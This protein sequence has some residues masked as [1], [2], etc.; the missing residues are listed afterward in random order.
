MEALAA[1]LTRERLLVELVVFKLVE[2]R[3]LLLAGEAR[4]LGWAAEEVERADRCR[5]R[6]AELERA[7]LVTGLATDRGLPAG[8]A[9]A[10]RPG[11]GRARAVAHACSPRRRRAL[12]AERRRGGRAADRHAP[13]RRG[14]QPRAGRDACASSTAHRTRRSRCAP[15]TA[16]PPA[17]RPPVPAPASRTSCSPCQLLRP[18]ASAS[19]RWP[20]P[21]AP[22]RSRR[23]TSPTPT[24][25]ASPGS[26]SPCR[27]RC[28]P[29]ARPGCAATDSAAWASRSCR[30]TACA[31]GW[32]TSPGAARPASRRPRRARAEGLT[33]TESVVGNYGAGAPERAVGVPVGLGRPEPAPERRRGPQHRPVDRR[34]PRRQPARPAPRASTASAPSCGPRIG[35]QLGELNGLLTHVDGAQQG[36]PARRG[37]R[38][39]PQ[40]PATTSATPRSTAS[41]RCPAP[42]VRPGADG[43][44]EVYLGGG[45]ARWP[46][47]TSRSCRPRAPVPRP[48]CARPTAADVPAG[49]QL[50]GY[51]SVLKADLPPFGSQ[52]DALAAGL[53]DAGERD[54]RPQPGPRRRAGRRV[55]HRHRRPRPARCRPRSP[56]ARSPRAC[57]A[58]RDDGEGALAMSTLRTL[59]AVDGQPLGAAVR[60]FG[61]RVGQAVTDAGRSSGTAQ[62]GPAGRDADPQRRERR[63]HRRGDGRPREVPARLLGGLARHHHRRRDAGQDHQRDG[64]LMRV[65]T[66]N[67][68]LTS[69][70]GLGA[71]LGRVQEQS[72]KLSSGKSISK[73][74][75][76]AP[77]AATAEALRAGEAD[78]ESFA[79]SAADAKGWLD[80]ADG[81]L[82][83]MSSV[84]IRVRELAASAVNGSL[85]ATSR[86]AI[87]DE[88]A[89][90]RDQLRDL[91]QTRY[92]DRPLFGGFGGETGSAL[93]TDAR[94][95]GHL[96]GRQRAGAPPGQPDRAPAGQRRRPGAV[97]LRHR[98]GRGRLRDPRRPVDRGPR[99]RRRPPSPRCRAALA[100]HADAVGRGLA[101]VGA[102]TNRV[103]SVVD[104]GSTVARRPRQ[105]PQRASRTSTSPRPSSSST[106]RR[107]AT[108]PRSAPP[109][110]PTCRAWRTSSGS[111]PPLT[112]A[113][114][115]Q[116]GHARTPPGRTPGARTTTDGRTPRTSPMAPV[117]RPLCSRRAPP[118]RRPAPPCSTPS[119]RSS[120]RWPADVDAGLVVAAPLL[121]GRDRAPAGQPRPGRA[122]SS[123]TATPPPASARSPSPA[124]GPP[125]A[126]PSSSTRPPCPTGPACVR[127]RAG[128][129][130]P[131][132]SCCPP[133]C[134]GV[135]VLT[136]AVDLAAL[137]ALVLSTQPLPVDDGD[138]G[139][140][141][142]ARA[143]PGVPG[144]PGLVS[145]VVPVW[146]QLE[147]TRACLASL[148]RT[149]RAPYEVVVVD[150]GSTDGTRAWLAAQRDVVVVTNAENRGFAAACNQGVAA[151]RGEVVV[152]LNNDTQV[153]RGWVEGL[154]DA[155]RR[156]P[157]DRRR[158]PPL[159]PRLRP[160]GRCTSPATTP[161]RSTAPPPSGGAA[162]T[163]AAAPTVHPAGRLL[164]RRPPRRAAARPAAWTRATAP[165]A[166]RTTTSACA[167]AG[168]AGPSGSP[169]RCSSTT[170]AARP[171]APPAP[172]PRPS[173]T[174]TGTTAPSGAPPSART[175]CVGRPHRQGRAGGAAHLPGRPAR[176]RRRG[177]RLRHRQ[178]RPHRRGR[179]G[180]RRP[181]RARA[182]GGRLR[183]RPQRRPGRLPRH[184]GAVAS[185][186][187]SSCTWRPAPTCASPCSRPRT[188]PPR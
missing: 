171:L 88:V 95:A 77:A 40:R 168:P 38:L 21:S 162:R 70:A 74:S 155:L 67:V 61:A 146:N 177:R 8:R 32:P 49:G 169:T 87:A 7:V 179:R 52:L 174:P 46:A 26:A 69:A 83:S 98:G 80:A 79:R 85:S 180:L 44:S 137:A 154:L 4:F 175:S 23:T 39:G 58:A 48:R 148:R 153:A 57:P 56:S 151:S 129:P 165:A 118:A 62:A 97:R 185:T 17:G 18:A 126:T 172:T 59:P 76:D 113:R 166:S 122:R 184:L 1:L 121:H 28:R 141:A 78:L 5:S 125:A 6:Q 167:C 104:A 140:G 92:L 164:P 159:E 111:R 45:A 47:A 54:P 149:T 35:D 110:R 31:T 124:P 183:R 136:A 43:R 106:P 133:A 29:R 65:T 144:R 120:Q 143:R 9:D 173:G 158:R 55:L 131:A 90:L 103:A 119:A 11:R 130:R 66:S 109:P 15:P 96:R 160:P 186:P 20:P 41:P 36:H 30:S 147:H 22:S 163:P 152:L 3:Q 10:V 86:A 64:H 101:Q 116:A 138:P 84:L 139:A 33:R 102:T 94:R 114:R 127:S 50:G 13:P 16:R 187:T 156:R 161:R 188:T 91:G 60:A 93:A 73:W 63:Q 25:R 107:P 181:R 37:R 150:N 2:L 12:R 145:V 108:R 27:P 71:A 19:P 75:D 14:R 99:Q 89:Q 135:P 51:L 34:R 68:Y 24:P 115:P 81:T 82:Q 42:R 132:A 117:P 112:S 134:S 72:A 123:S 142:R 176:R 182:L 157:P 128:R 178:H 100:D 105:P 53:R 170:R